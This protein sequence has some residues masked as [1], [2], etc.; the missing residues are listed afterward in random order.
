MAESRLQ[1][2]AVAE[3]LNKMMLTVICISSD[4]GDAVAVTSAVRH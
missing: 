2:V 1:T 4:S 3:A